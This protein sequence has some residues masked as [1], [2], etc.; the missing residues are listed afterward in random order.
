METLLDYISHLPYS[1]S[2]PIKS[3]LL[4]AQSTSP[5]ASQVVPLLLSL[6][7]L[8]YTLLSA[9][10][11]ARFALRSVWFMMKWGTI[12]VALGGGVAGLSKWNK[13]G[14]DGGS[15]LGVGD[16]IGLGK[17]G[18]DWWGADRRSA[19]GDSRRSAS[20]AHRTWSRSNEDGEWDDPSESTLGAALGMEDITSKI[21][22]VV[23]T[24]LSNSNS[25][26]TREESTRKSRSR[27]QKG[28]TE[29]SGSIDVAGLVMRYGASQARKAWGRFAGL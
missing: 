18:L 3:F 6:V 20:G 4:Q 22:E 7:A 10:N 15:S 14:S 17:R 24:F 29:Q 19:F 27:K 25:V 5:T 2:Q 11:T 26:D 13:G 21:G 28:K 12:L 23:M 16:M 8:Y 9:Y 1:F